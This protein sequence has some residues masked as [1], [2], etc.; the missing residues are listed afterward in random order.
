MIWRRLRP[1]ESAGT[2]CKGDN[3]IIIIVRSSARAETTAA[4]GNVAA[5]Y[6]KYNQR[7]AALDGTSAN[8]RINQSTN[9]WLYS[10]LAVIVL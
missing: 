2:A 5:T 3:E 8:R 10:V 9:P 1:L 7:T 4:A 6:D